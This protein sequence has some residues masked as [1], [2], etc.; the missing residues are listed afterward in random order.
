MS[1]STTRSPG[2][3]MLSTATKT[4]TTPVAGK[5]IKKNNDICLSPSVCL[6]ANSADML[7]RQ[8]LA[9]MLLTRS[10]HRPN[11]SACTPHSSST[12]LQL[13]CYPISFASCLFAIF[14]LLLLLLVTL[15]VF[16]RDLQ[17]SPTA[18]VRRRT[19]NHQNRQC[20]L[21]RW[22]SSG[23]YLAI[24]G[25]SIVLLIIML[26]CSQNWASPTGALYSR[27]CE[28]IRPLDVRSALSF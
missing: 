15:S 17:D 10:I 8:T 28:S 4:T 6:R 2:P 14:L 11:K 27:E 24:W 18:A 25:E 22:N 3:A 19:T 9:E 12:I 7:R 20:Q 26:Q 23:L 13:C 1:W 5:E 21:I 16:F